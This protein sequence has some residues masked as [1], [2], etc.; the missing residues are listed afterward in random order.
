MEIKIKEL[1]KDI[2]FNFD[3]K[4]YKEF[5][6]D[7]K[8]LGKKYE[9]KSDSNKINYSILLNCRK[10]PNYKVKGWASRVITKKEGMKE[11]VFI[12]YD[13]ILL[14]LVKE[15]LKFL[16]KK[17]NLSP[18]YLYK[19]FET[20]AKDGEV[21]GNYLA[22]SIAKKNYGEVIEILKN[23]HADNSYKVVPTSYP[24]KTW[25]LRLGKKFNK[26]EP[27]FK[28]IVGDLKKDYNMSCSQAHLEILEQISPEVKGKIKYKN[29][30]GNK[31]V[32]LS[33]YLTAS[34]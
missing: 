28:C 20:N 29:L 27:E 6:E 18:F 17:Y 30:D 34:H 23:T 24:Y 11:V 5:I 22:V 8:K 31:E 2:I 16:T 10:K 21:Y 15:E 4:N 13:N 33:E 19:S 9:F 7:I 32:H 3:F 12:D 1:G 26:K 25:V 14:R